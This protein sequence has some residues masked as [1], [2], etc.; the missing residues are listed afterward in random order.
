MRR[1]PGRNSSRPAGSPGHQA[2]FIAR[3]QLSDGIGGMVA[4]N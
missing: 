2:L 3:I 1:L 4:P